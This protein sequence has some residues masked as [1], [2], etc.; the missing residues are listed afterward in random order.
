[1]LDRFEY[2]Y[3]AN[4]ASRSCRYVLK[5]ETLQ[6]RSR[7]DIVTFFSSFCEYRMIII[8]ASV[9]LSVRLYFASY[10]AVIFALYDSLL[11]AFRLCVNEQNLN[12]ARHHCRFE[13]GLF[14][15]ARLCGFVYALLMCSDNF[16]SLMEVKAQFN[17]LNP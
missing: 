3:W 5:H 1:M 4:E 2:V 9:L 11:P 6:G 16:N 17:I 15:S 13:V 14:E 10:C 12:H 7:I 8:L